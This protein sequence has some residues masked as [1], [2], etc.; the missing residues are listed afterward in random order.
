M[1][2]QVGS[3]ELLLSEAETLCRQAREA[4]VEAELDVFEGLWH[5]FQVHTGMLEEADVALDRLGEFL[6]QASRAR[7]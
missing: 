4:G 2:I 1:L 6:S 7:S 5:D 3:N